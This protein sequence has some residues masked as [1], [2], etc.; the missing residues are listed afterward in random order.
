MVT[1]QWW[2]CCL[3]NKRYTNSKP[4]LFLHNTTTLHVSK[5]NAKKKKIKRKR[6]E[7][8]KEKEGRGGGN[9]EKN[10][11]S[12]WKK[13]KKLPSHYGKMKKGGEGRGEHQVKDKIIFVN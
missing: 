4:F 8:Q 1:L 12:S 6:K 9:T 2:L 5:S 3:R 7:T 13:K 10:T 11:E